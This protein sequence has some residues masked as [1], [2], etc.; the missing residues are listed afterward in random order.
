[1][2]KCDNENFNMQTPPNTIPCMTC[3]HKLQPVVLEDGTVIDKPKYGMC[4]KYDRKPY[5]VLW[6][7]EQCDKYE[8]EE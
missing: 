8:E 7:G 4:G 5:G 1:M 6:Q 2:A 3:K